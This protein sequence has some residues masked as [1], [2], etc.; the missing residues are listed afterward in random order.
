VCV[1]VFTALF[2]PN[3]ER[4]RSKWSRKETNIPEPSSTTCKERPV[5][6]MWMVR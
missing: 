1:C 6:C 5:L 2:H 4:E 3:F